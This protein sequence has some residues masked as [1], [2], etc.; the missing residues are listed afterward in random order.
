VKEML[1]FSDTGK[2][3]RSRVLS[4]VAVPLTA[5]LLA[6][7]ALAAA[8]D[9]STQGQAFPTARQIAQHEGRLGHSAGVPLPTSR[10]VLMHEGRLATNPPAA[11]PSGAPASGGSGEGALIAGVA[12]GSLI[13]LAAGGFVVSRR[14]R[15]GR[16]LQS[17]A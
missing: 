3:H 16:A 5:A 4:L 12:G 9:H 10:Q 15:S 6:T 1:N 11:A 2:R 17:G 7:P 14:V 8:K 13:L